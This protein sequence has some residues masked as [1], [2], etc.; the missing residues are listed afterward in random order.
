MMS[1]TLRRILHGRIFPDGGYRG[2][3]HV[4]R[5]HGTSLRGILRLPR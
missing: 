5:L 2:A 3:H 1:M 4:L